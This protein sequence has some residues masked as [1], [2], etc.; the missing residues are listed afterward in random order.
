V[1]ATCPMVYTGTLTEGMVAGRV[2]L[3][4]ALASHGDLSLPLARAPWEGTDCRGK[5][6]R[7]PGR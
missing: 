3:V 2:W 5:G 7:M 4:I 6:S 1:G